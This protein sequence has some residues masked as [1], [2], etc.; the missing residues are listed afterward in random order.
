L[1]RR[2]KLEIDVEQGRAVETDEQAGF[3][4]VLAGKRAQQRSEAGRD[5]PA[6]GPAERRGLLRHHDNQIKIR[7]AIEPT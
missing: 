5:L 6:L 7:I 4:D 1:E 3:V 2:E